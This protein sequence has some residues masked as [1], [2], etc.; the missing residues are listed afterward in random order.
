V[1]LLHLKEAETRLHR[2]AGVTLLLSQNLKK[3]RRMTRLEWL[4]NVVL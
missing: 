2:K 1:I 3:N 4:H